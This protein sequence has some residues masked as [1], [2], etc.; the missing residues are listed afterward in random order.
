[1]K[2][3]EPTIPLPDATGHFGQYGGVFVP[4][5]LIYALQQLEKEYRRAK[6]DPKFQQELE[7][8]LHEYVGRPSGLY[9]A[10]RLTEHWGGAKVYL[11]REDLNHTGAHKINSAIGQALLTIRMGKK[12]VIAET[13]AGQHGVATATAAALFGLK[14]DVFMGAEDVRRQNLNVFRMKLMGANVVEVHSGGKTLKDATNEAMRDWMGSVQDTHYIIGSVVGPHP[15]PMIVRDFQ[16]V[17]GREAREQCMAKEGRLPDYVIACVGGGSNAA[18]IFAPFADDAQVKLVGVEAGGR[19]TALGQ[20]AA[21]LTAG[22]PGVLHGSLSYV[23][24]TDD[25]QTAEVHS[26]SAGL[27]YPGVGPEHAYWKDTG[28]VEY[29]SITDAEALDA[30][31]KVAQLEGILPALESSHAF[32]YAAKLAPT[33]SKDQIIILNLSGRGDKDCQEVARLIGK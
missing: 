4:E 26:V 8:Y 13:G 27:D 21:S 7:D 10:R 2:L 6:A 11:K 12:R 22:Q 20:H 30:F 16:A 19:G 5:T 31:Q 9:F 25:G 17:I 33:L 28:R 29:V 3:T 14:C 23:L 1:M 15:F 18:G 32:A 24:Q